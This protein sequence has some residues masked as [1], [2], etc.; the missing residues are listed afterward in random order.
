MQVIRVKQVMS[1]MLAGLYVIIST[2]TDLDEAD[3]DDQAAGARG[4]GSC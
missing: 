1:A 3:Q 4:D 2:S